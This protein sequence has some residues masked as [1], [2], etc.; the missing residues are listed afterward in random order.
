MSSRNELLTPEQRK[1]ANEINRI[2]NEA[3]NI[4]HSKTV[5]EIKSFVINKININNFLEVEYFDIVDDEKLEQIKNWN[6]NKSK[7]GCIAVF[8]GSIRL[9]DN[10]YFD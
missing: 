1:N 3:K 10:I 4:A 6:E 9:I 8:C 2:L 5:E 7:V